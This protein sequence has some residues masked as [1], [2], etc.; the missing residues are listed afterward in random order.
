MADLTAIGPESYQ[1]W[2]NPLPEGEVVRLGR[3]PRNGWKVAWDR[4][5]SREHAD[6]IW[7]NGQLRV[8]CLG[9]ARNPVV[10]EGKKGGK[11]LLAVGD[12]FRIGHTQFLVSATDDMR[13]DLFEEITLDQEDSTEGLA[14]AGRRLRYVM[15]LPGIIART[16]SDEELAEQLTVLLLEALQRPAPRRQFASKTRRNWNPAD[17][18]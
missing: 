11:F 16:R 14:D 6:L 18:R 15:R 3:A 4:N 5:I 13:D 7:Q 9:T 17:G 12:S 8:E 10:V 1:R 2:Q